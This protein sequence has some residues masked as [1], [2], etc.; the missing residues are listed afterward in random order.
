[1]YVRY[2]WFMV[3]LIYGVAAPG[4]QAHAGDIF[5]KNQ[6]RLG[7]DLETFVP[8]ADGKD[9]HPA[10]ER[11]PDAAEILTLRQA[12]AD[13]LMHSPD[14]AAFAWDVRAAEAREL[15]G[16]LLPNPELEA[17]LEN[18]A[19][20]DELRRF[21]SAETTIQISQLFEL[22]G[23]R[24]YRRQAAAFEKDVAGWD[25][26]I[27]RLEV[28]EKIA[29]A[30]WEM[31]AAQERV[32]LADAL[33][34]LDEQVRADA[35][36]RV[37]A[38]RAEP[39]EE[40]QARITLT[41]SELQS[42]KE[43]ND[44]HS[45][46]ISLAAGM[47]TSEAGFAGVRGDFEAL[48]PLPPFEDIQ[49]ALEESPGMRRWKAELQKL[50]AEAALTDAGAVPDVT[51]S[52]GARYFNDTDDR[53]VLAGF[54]IPIPLF[55]RNQ[56]GRQEARCNI[57]RAKQEMR[58]MSMQ[59]HSDIAA[60]YQS[61]LSSFTLAA[62]LRDTSIPAAQRT[63]DEVQKGFRMGRFSRLEVLESRRGLLELRQQYID[64]LLDYH[65]GSAALERMLGKQV[66]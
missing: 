43:K 7:S 13:G 40:L 18:F 11:V 22:G 61:C 25:Y 23:K 30:F 47:G 34:R 32:V 65:T 59:L 51:V 38:G 19:G 5:L 17:E 14:L 2:F 33:V 21:R 64:A 57:A 8:P 15:Q 16:G 60:A 24:G 41:A 55:D 36:E 35:A 10:P 56:G 29:A 53:A 39:F 12:L 44:L 42:V 9:V 66:L 37:A 48:S 46:R 28:F 52:A 54:S 63:F 4:A 20:D 26:E 58:S 45:A 3:L 50:Q 27:K 6:R 1:M 31:L 49:A 62:A